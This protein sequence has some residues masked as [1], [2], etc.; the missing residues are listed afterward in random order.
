MIW[1][2]SAALPPYEIDKGQLGSSAAISSNTGFKLEA[3]K[4][5]KGFGADARTPK[6]DAR[7]HPAPK[8]KILRRF[9][10][11]TTRYCRPQR[12]AQGKNAS[13]R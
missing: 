4:M 11:I 8:P 2:A 3:A 1:R 9:N 13:C 6:A 10:F 7:T 5:T 12:Q